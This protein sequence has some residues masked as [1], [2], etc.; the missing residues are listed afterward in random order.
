MQETWV[1]SLDWEDPLEKGIAT[2][3]SIFAWTS[4]WTEEPGGLQSIGSQRVGRDWVT[5]T[6]TYF[7]FYLTCSFLWVWLPWWLKWS[8]ICLQCRRHGFDPWVRKIPWRRKWQPT[9][10]L[11]PGESRGQRY[12]LQCCKETDT[13]ER[14]KLSSVSMFSF[15]TKN[16]KQIY[17]FGCAGSQL[18]SMGSSIFTVACGIFSFG[19][20]TLISCSMWDLVPWPEMEPRALALGAQSLNCR[21]TREVPLPKFQQLWASPRQQGITVENY[22][23]PASSKHQPRSFLLPFYCSLVPSSGCFYILIGIHN[24][25]LKRIDPSISFHRYCKTLILGFVLLYWGCL[26]LFEFLICDQVFLYLQMFKNV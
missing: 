15:I 4:P 7:L 22:P 23:V 18:Q 14:L 26:F 6:F 19:M 17:L 16:F 25:Y 20:R 5:N 3:S 8:R 12:S 2:H 10:V 21:P 9:P 1:R 24:C 11:L 13:T